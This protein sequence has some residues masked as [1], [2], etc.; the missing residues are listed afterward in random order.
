VKKSETKKESLWKRNISI[1]LGDY[2]KKHFGEEIILNKTNISKPVSVAWIKLSESPKPGDEIV[3]NFSRD[4]GTKDIG[5]VEGTR[6]VF[7]SENWQQPACIV[8]M[9]DAKLTTEAS[10][11][12]VGRSGN[13]K[14]AWMISL[15][16]IAAL[17]IAFSFYHRLVLPKPES[18]KPAITAP[19]S[20]V[21]K[22]FWIALSSY[23]I[24]KNI[25]VV[26][27]FL[28]F[29]RFAESQLVKLASPFLLDST[30]MGGLGLTT[31]NLG[32]VYGTIG[33]IALSLG[34]IIGGILVSRNGLKYWFWWMIAAMNIPHLAY[35][36]LSWAMP[37]DIW[38]IAANVAFEQLG[39]GFGF[40]AYMVYMLYTAQGKH[41]TSHFAIS[42]GFMA[43]GMM[44]PGM[45]SGWLQDIIGYHN[46]FIWVL[47]CGIPGILVGLFVKID[48]EFGKKKKEISESK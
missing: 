13:I 1:P 43:L 9:P 28:L 46:F 42:T 47:I 33:I 41:Q 22:E 24:R 5:I 15:L 34:G 8:F 26:L 14:L 37:S 12:F 39:Y 23:F 6:F 31:G 25:L 21:F 45:L 40:T 36:Y 4:K 30:E 19:G 32:L 27:S 35:V 17:F 11:V 18:D 48:P 10:T 20:N 2:I 38:I 29:Y 7:T 3:V 44:I 16:V